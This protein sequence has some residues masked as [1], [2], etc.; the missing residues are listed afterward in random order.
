[1]ETKNSNICTDSAGPTSGDRNHG[2]KRF[3]ESLRE[4]LGLQSSG[5]HSFPA[6][7]KDIIRVF[8]IA[9]DKNENLTI[10]Q[11]ACTV[12]ESKTGFQNEEIYLEPYALL[13]THSKALERLLFCL[14]EFDLI[15]SAKPH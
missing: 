2:I 7:E 14:Y 13:D 6:V 15:D 3:V 1:M 12:E 9:I 5:L 10:E 11:C 4:T 8:Y